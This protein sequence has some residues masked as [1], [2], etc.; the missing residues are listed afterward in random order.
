MDTEDRHIASDSTEI[1]DP[2]PHTNEWMECI[3]HHIL[4]RMPL[5][6]LMN[7]AVVKLG[8][9]KTTDFSVQTVLKEA[10]Y[11]MDQIRG[12]AWSM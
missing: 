2:F 11:W 3:S 6:L 9:V 4:D 10:V 7:P 5:P 12:G 1:D 8:D